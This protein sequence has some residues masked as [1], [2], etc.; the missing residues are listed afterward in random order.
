M[1][2]IWISPGST[3]DFW[4]YVT[5]I[6][7]SESFFFLNIIFFWIFFLKFH[8]EALLAV[9]VMPPIFF[10]WIYFF[11]CYFPWIP[12]GSTPGWW[13]SRPSSSC[14][15]SPSPPVCGAW[16]TP[17]PSTWNCFCPST[18]C[19][20]CS[21]RWGLISTSRGLGRYIAILYNF[22][23]TLGT[24]SFCIQFKVL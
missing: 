21:W 7:L 16:S 8:R 17:G 15:C 22:I 18:C 20:S 3:P 5:H 13:C 10:F 23:E 11:L 24:W 19:S 2:F 12:P 4:C 9:G 6:F 14:Q 1:F